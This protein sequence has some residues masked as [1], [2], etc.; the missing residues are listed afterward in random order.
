MLIFCSLITVT[1][2]STRSPSN[3]RLPTNLDAP[4]FRLPSLTLSL[5]SSIYQRSILLTPSHFTSH[6]LHCL[7]HRRRHQTAGF[8][9]PSLSPKRVWEKPSVSHISG[10][11][12]PIQQCVVS[13]GETSIRRA[14]RHNTNIQAARP[15]PVSCLEPAQ[16]YWRGATIVSGI[17]RY[18]VADDLDFLTE[19]YSRHF[20]LLLFPP[21]PVRPHG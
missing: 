15:R 9:S 19:A 7:R 16:A 10:T 3:P 12:R 18:V 14:N 11:L 21:T 6:T 5:S 13:V 4:V 8:W 20:Y 17:L 1:I 2:L